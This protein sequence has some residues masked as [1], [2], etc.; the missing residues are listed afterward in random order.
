MEKTVKIDGKDVVL[1][2]SAYNLVLYRAEFGMDIFQAKADIFGALVGN[3][4]ELQKVD[5]ISDFEDNG[6]YDIVATNWQVLSTGDPQWFLDSMYK[7]GSSSNYGQYSN[8]ELDGIIEKLAQTFDI[9]GRE[10]LTIEAEKVL[11]AD[12]A[13]IYL[14]GENN[15]VVAS[16]KVQNVVPYPIDYYFIDNRLSI[17]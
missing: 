4:I 9:E 5:S 6:E 14:V 1:K 12:A 7:T 16:S 10:A 2:A 11:L 15:F 17:E 13:S 3:R 8:E